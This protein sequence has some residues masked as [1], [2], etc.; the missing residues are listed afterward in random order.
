MILVQ[1][2]DLRLALAFSHSIAKLNGLLANSRS[3]GC[4]RKQSLDVGTLGIDHGLSLGRS[5]RMSRERSR[6]RGSLARS[7]R[8]PDRR[9]VIVNLLPGPTG[10]GFAVETYR[11]VDPPRAL[12]E[13]QRRGRSKVAGTIESRT[14]SGDSNDDEPRRGVPCAL[15]RSDSR[16]AIPHVSAA[17]PLYTGTDKVLVSKAF[18]PGVRPTVPS[19]AFDAR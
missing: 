17:C 3:T 8:V 5:A 18:R 11:S 7:N 6:T 2:V 9:R 14:Q 15:A 19:G 13:K 10:T 1:Q 4:L 16:D 12:C